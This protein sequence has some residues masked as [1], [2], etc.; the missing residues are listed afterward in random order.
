MNQSI[1]PAGIERRRAFTVARPLNTVQNS[2][3]IKNKPLIQDTPCDEISLDT[4]EFKLLPTVRKDMSKEA[5]VSA[6]FAKK[7]GFTR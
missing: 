7:R 4:Q 1:L 5:S 3:T 2:P 6:S